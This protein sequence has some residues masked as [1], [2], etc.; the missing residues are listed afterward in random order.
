MKLL[1]TY[2]SI[3]SVLPQQNIV[4]SVQNNFQLDLQLSYIYGGK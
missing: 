2:I 3:F 1:C 4:P